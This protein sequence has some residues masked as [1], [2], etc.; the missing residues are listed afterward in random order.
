MM[1]DIEIKVY[2]LQWAEKCLEFSP[3]NTIRLSK[4]SETGTLSGKSTTMCCMKKYFSDECQSI[5]LLQKDLRFT[6]KN[7][8][9]T[10]KTQINL[11]QHRSTEIYF[12]RNH[13]ARNTSEKTVYKRNYHLIGFCSQ[14]PF[15]RKDFEIDF[16]NR[17][18]Y[19]KKQK[20]TDDLK[21]PC[22]DNPIVRLKNEHDEC[23]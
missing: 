13:Y 23:L 5:I 12:C 2:S 19:T 16:T 3:G 21:S 8:D 6:R 7:N 11:I 15:T 20:V 14:E 22:D 18:R 1:K 4:L 10:C 9:S 17:P